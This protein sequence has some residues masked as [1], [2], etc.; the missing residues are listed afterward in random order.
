MRR[1]LLAC[2]VLALA[3]C[4]GNASI[5]VSGAAT[6]EDAAVM[7][8]ASGAATFTIAIPREPVKAK[9]LSP[10]TK[11]L[12]IAAN[13]KKLGTFDVTPTSK[14]CS[15]L[16][17]STQCRFSLLVPVGSVT[18]GVATYSGLA[19]GGSVLSEGSVTQKVTSGTQAV[20]ALT[21]SGVVA[22]IDVQLGNPRLTAGTAASTQVFVTA[23]DAAGAVIVGP[24]NFSQPIVL[25]DSDKTGITRLSTS[26]V[27]G[28]GTIVTLAYDGKSLTSAIIGAGAKGVPTGESTAATFVPSPAVVNNYLL[29]SVPGHLPAQNIVNG[30]DG[31]LWIATASI[32]GIVKMTTAGVTTFYQ[33]GVVTNLPNQF[34]SGLAAGSDGNVWYATT[35]HVGSI[36]PAGTVTD[37]AFSDGSCHA[38]QIVPAAASDGGFWLTTTGCN[39]SHLDHVDTSG[40]VTTFALPASFIISTSNDGALLLG[41]DGNVYVTGRDFNSSERDL[42]QAVVTGGNTVTATHVIGVLPGSSDGGLSGI[43][44]TP[45][46]ELW[47]TSEGC[48]ASLLVRVH[49]ATTFV[50]STVDTYPTL[51]SCSEPSSIVALRDGTLWVSEYDYNIVTRVTPGVYPAA[52][53]LFDLAVPAPNS[54]YEDMAAVA[55]GSDGNLYF[56]DDTSSSTSSGNIVK[57]AY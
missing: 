7:R 41:K 22:S 43:A 57:L 6:P 5:P 48:G 54:L 21:L 34:V 9:Y 38:L 19:G 4:N 11:S 30:P 49:L 50:A 16:N 20:I 15:F 37:H 28:P 24:G 44:Q 31:N 2:F 36:S 47:L 42:L 46:G 52:P 25:T 39:P 23:R 13:G 27:K 55:I 14:G 56:T 45:S 51:A 29:P 18:F 12:T 32:F 10:K 3:A 33:G 40:N 53:A 8:R 35:A 17:G 1:L 26:S